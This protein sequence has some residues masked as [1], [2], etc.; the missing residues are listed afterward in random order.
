LQLSDLL[1]PN[2]KQ[3]PE[4][5]QNDKVDVTNTPRGAFNY[6]RHDVGPSKALLCSQELDKASD[7]SGQESNS[8]PENVMNLLLKLR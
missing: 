6:Q 2:N 3:A 5:Y 4:G 1:A 7:E 8:S